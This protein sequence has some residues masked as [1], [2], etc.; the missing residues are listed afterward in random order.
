MKIANIRSSAPRKGAF[1]P[2][3]F[4]AIGACVREWYRRYRGRRELEKLD[5]AMLQDLGIGPAD[6]WREAS[7]RFWKC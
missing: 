1:M 7:K 3:G 6:A 4:A 2:I 5:R